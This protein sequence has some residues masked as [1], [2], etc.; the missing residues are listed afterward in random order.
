MLMLINKYV[1]RDMKEMARPTDDP[2]ERY[3]TFIPESISK[4]VQPKGLESQSKRILHL[5]ELGLLQ[6]KR[7]KK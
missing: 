4:A 7:M 2:C 3:V 5:I 6:E 1:I